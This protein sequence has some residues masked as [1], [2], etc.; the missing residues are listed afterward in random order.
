MTNQVDQII[1]QAQAAAQTQDYSSNAAVDMSHTQVAPR[2]QVPSH[3]VPATNPVPISMATAQAAN[4]S[5]DDWLKFSYHGISVAEKP[6]ALFDE[7]TVEIDMTEGSGF[8]IC[9]MVRYGK[10]PVRYA[11]TFDQV[12]DD[13]GAPWQTTLQMIANIDPDARPYPAAKIPMIV[14]EDVTGGNGKT[15]E[16]VLKVGQIAAYTTPVTGWDNWARFYED[17]RKAGKLG[18]IVKVKVSNMP[19]E[20][21]TYTWGVPKFELLAD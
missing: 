8:R 18:E 3:L 16:I 10:D 1:N 9:H 17:V 5:A 19:R 7:L 21:K 15:A 2:S 13:K 20:K 4:M 14:V 12:T 11:S 6:R